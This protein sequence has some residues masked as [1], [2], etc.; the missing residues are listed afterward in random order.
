MKVIDV[1][2]IVKMKLFQDAL[3]KKVIEKIR[4]KNKSNC[5]LY[6]L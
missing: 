5:Q 1:T 6:W 2:H 3:L 4:W